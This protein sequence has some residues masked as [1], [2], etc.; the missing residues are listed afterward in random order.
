[1]KEKQYYGIPEDVYCSVLNNEELIFAD[2]R[3]STPARYRR[4]RTIVIG[5][6]EHNKTF[7][8]LG[9]EIG[10]SGNRAR[11]LFC[12]CVRLLRRA[13][14]EGG[15]DVSNKTAWE[16]ISELTKKELLNKIAKEAC[17]DQFGYQG[18]F[19]HIWPEEHRGACSRDC[20]KCWTELPE[21]EM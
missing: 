16:S 12:W 21:V 9:S 14:D 6:I 11:Q 18:K 8:E 4:A 5:R 7:R 19:T 2:K 10:V 13:T 1:V 20:L 17:P 15:K 3:P